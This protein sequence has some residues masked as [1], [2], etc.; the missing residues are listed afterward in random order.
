[1]WGGGGG[2]GGG[3]GQSGEGACLKK[4]K[5]DSKFSGTLKEWLFE[6][7]GGSGHSL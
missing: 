1:M 7:T 2:G 6:V 5:K 3:G 4:N